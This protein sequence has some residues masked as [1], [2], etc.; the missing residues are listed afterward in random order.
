[1]PIG[2]IDDGAFSAGAE[3]IER[4]HMGT[5]EIGDV[6]IIAN[7]GAIGRFIIGTENTHASAASRCG[8]GGC[9]NEMGSTRRGLART[10]LRIGACD[11]EI[12]QDH[13]VKAI[14]TRGIFKHPFDHQL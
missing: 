6:N 1:M 10:S 7:T 8:F 14:G 5:G 2:A 11:I 4:Q 13:G 9:F 3:I 12:A